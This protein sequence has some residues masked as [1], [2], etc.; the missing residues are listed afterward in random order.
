[1]F[2]RQTLKLAAQ[3]AALFLASVAVLTFGIL[4]YMNSSSNGDY[5]RDIGL[6]GGPKP[7]DLEAQKTADAVQD[8]LEKGL[9]MINGLLLITIPFV[10]YRMARS[11]LKPIQKS[12][13]DQQQFVDNASHELKTPIS[14]ISGELQLAIS[15][16]RTPADYERAIKLSLAEVDNLANLTENLTLLARGDSEKVQQGFRVVDLDEVIRDCL[17]AAESAA[18]AAGVKCEYD[19][20]KDAMVMGEK[21]LLGP[22]IFNL[23]DNAIKYS[24]LGSKVVVSLGREG[25]AWLVSVHDRG[26]G[27]TEPEL[28]LATR[29]F[30]RSDRVRETKGRGLGLAIAAQIAW[31]HHGAITLRNG[32]EK[33]LTAEVRLPSANA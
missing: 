31:L 15:R 4:L 11:A 20:R 9:L 6:P 16:R 29:R 25:E 2:D 7:S 1:M 21:S 5:L 23:V 22:M 12:L 19:G 17:R 8:R 28:D 18:G 13:E 10:S 33:G 32:T 30:W 24:P 26:P 3:Y 27:M 14:V